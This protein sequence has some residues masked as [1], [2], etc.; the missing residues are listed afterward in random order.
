VYKRGDIL[1]DREQDSEVVVVQLSSDR[2]D[3]Y[4][5]K[6]R[7]PSENRYS[8]Q[9]VYDFNARY[10]YVEPTE[11]VVQAVYSESL[12]ANPHELTKDGRA[13]LVRNV[14]AQDTDVQ[15]YAFPVSRLTSTDDS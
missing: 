3:E 1:T 7:D 6:E 14:V 11:P 10:D 9:T 4:V 15:T 2:A 13:I 12:P 5:V 8:D